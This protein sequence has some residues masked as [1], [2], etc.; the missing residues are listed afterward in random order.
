[1]IGSAGMPLIFLC[2][3]WCRFN[4]IDGSTVNAS[5]ALGT[6]I[7]NFSHNERCQAVATETTLARILLL[8]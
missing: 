7:W 8:R 4:D 6:I 3:R 1:M 2:Q 5:K